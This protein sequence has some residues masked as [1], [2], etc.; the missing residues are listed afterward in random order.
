MLGQV[1]AACQAKPTETVLSV[2]QEARK[3]FPAAA[4]SRWR[5]D[6]TTCRDYAADT[7]NGSGFVI[8]LDGY[9]RGKSGK[10]ASVLNDDATLNAYF[11]ACAKKPDALMLDV[12]G[13]SAR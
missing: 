4:E 2:W 9:N 6:K 8:W 12:M 13:E 11:D 10:S 5:A 7:D 1:Y 3:T